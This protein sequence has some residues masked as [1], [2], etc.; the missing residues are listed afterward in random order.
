MNTYRVAQVPTAN[1]SFEIVERELPRPGFRQ[2]CIA[3][4]ACG[5]CHSDAL[6]VSAGM[7]GVPF[8]LVPG[9]E[10]AGRVEELG[11]GADEMGWQV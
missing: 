8:P 1:G 6:F 10:V 9:H 5:V 2:V 4:E 3:M 11:D 7:P